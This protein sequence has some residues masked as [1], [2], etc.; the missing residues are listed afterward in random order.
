MKRN[1]FLLVFAI[2]IAGTTSARSATPPIARSYVH[3]FG[4]SA[5]ESMANYTIVI[6]PE[7]RYVNVEGG[8]V[9]RFIIGSQSFTW[10]FNVARTVGAFD[11]N[12]VAPPGM[13][14]HTV[15]AYVAPDPLYLLP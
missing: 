2:L 5:P 3:L 4:Q 15:R 8:E 9:V 6:R 11:L 13:L 1:L 14:D 12:E 7:T 10:H